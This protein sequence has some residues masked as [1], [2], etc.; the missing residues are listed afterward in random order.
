MFSFS[1]G[2][3]VASFPAHD[4]S[5]TGICVTKDHLITSSLDST[6]KIW[7]ITKV[8]TAPQLFYDHDDEII[9][10]DVSDES[11]GI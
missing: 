2:T 6:I 9:S 8:D 5:I 10:I 1:T 7:D 4:N 11:F 3:N